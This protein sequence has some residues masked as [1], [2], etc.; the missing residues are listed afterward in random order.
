MRKKVEAQESIFEDLGELQSL[1]EE[2]MLQPTGGVGRTSAAEQLTTHTGQMGAFQDSAV[3]HAEGAVEAQILHDATESAAFNGIESNISASEINQDVRETFNQCIAGGLLSN[4]PPGHS[5]EAMTK[6]EYQVEMQVEGE[7]GVTSAM[8][9]LDALVHTV[10]SGI[11]NDENAY[12][13]ALSAA[14]TAGFTTA[15][16]I[17]LQSSDVRHEIINDISNLETSRSSLNLSEIVEFAKDNVEDATGLTASIVGGQIEQQMSKSYEMD[18]QNKSLK[19]SDFISMSTLEVQGSARE[20]VASEGVRT[21]TAGDRSQEI[22]NLVGDIDNQTHIS[23]IMSD[24]DTAEKEE[25]AASDIQWGQDFN[26]VPVLSWPSAAI[27]ASEDAEIK[28]LE[29]DDKY[30]N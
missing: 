10:D 15:T 19:V 2:E 9:L 23:K 5:A 1:S 18:V 7:T 27:I 21:M 24:L 4:I 8:N 12:A 17:D 26:G 6:L 3:G 20:A 29:S 14:N 13:S 16:S 28:H 30:N 25:R 11:K 22:A